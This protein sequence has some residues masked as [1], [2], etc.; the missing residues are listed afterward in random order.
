MICLEA[1]KPAIAYEDTFLVFLVDDLMI[2][3][4]YARI[5][6]EGMGTTLVE[7]GIPCEGKLA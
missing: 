4:P 2:L 1:V 6:V 5:G 3:T 7:R